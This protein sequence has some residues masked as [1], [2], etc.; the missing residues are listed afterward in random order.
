MLW[1][2]LRVGKIRWKVLAVTFSRKP[3]VYGI[4]RVIIMSYV[5]QILGISSRCNTYNALALKRLRLKGSDKAIE[6][7]QRVEH[8]LNECRIQN[9]ARWHYN[10]EIDTTV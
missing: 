3:S 7:R 1:V 4:S 10:L 8:V 9:A 5:S 6:I 2:E